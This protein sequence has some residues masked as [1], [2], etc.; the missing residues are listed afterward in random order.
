MKTIHVN[1]YMLFLRRFICWI[2]I[3]FVIESFG[4]PA[5]IL[6]RVML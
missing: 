5:V 4:T 2:P 1:A 6:G 3:R